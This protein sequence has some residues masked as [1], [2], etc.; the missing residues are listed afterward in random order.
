MLHEF[1]WTIRGRISN[2]CTGSN[3][4]NHPMEVPK[5]FI[6][7]QYKPVHK[8]GLFENMPLHSATRCNFDCGRHFL[9]CICVQRSM[10]HIE[11]PPMPIKSH[12]SQGSV[13]LPN[14]RVLPRMRSAL[15][16][17]SRYAALKRTPPSRAIFR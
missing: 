11:Y 6:T 15:S 3:G 8:K 17:A 16:P 5:C 10:D 4:P 12:A 2:T 13:I 14:D 7:D 9:E 1:D